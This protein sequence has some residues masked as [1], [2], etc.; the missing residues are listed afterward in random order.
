MT[1]LCV[2]SEKS[3]AHSSGIFRGEIRL[4]FGEEK[5]G[6]VGQFSGKAT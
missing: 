6:Y 1:R 5:G 4:I 3:E 2:K